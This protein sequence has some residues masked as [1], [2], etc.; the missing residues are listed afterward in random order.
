MLRIIFPPKTVWTT[1]AEADILT[2]ARRLMDQLI[3]AVSG[4]QMS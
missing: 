3:L 1:A 4:K 2:G